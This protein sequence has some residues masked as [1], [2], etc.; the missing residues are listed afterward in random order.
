M[1][2]NIIR[3]FISLIMHLI[4]RG[5]IIVFNRL[6]QI[7]LCLSIC[8]TISHGIDKEIVFREVSYSV[9]MDNTQRAAPKI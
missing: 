3:D 8:L 9:K 7:L 5:F 6:F 2:G 4:F 1:S